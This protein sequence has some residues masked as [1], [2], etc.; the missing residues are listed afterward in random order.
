MHS[1]YMKRALDLAKAG[2]GR[3]SPNPTVGCVIVKNNQIIGEGRTA[4]GGRPHAEAV[5]LERAGQQAK[6]ATAYVT[7]EPCSHHGQ[8]PP[9]ARCLIDAG[10]KHVVVACED[11]NPQVAGDGIRMLQ[12]AGVQVSTG[13]CA[14]QAKALSAGFFLRFSEKRPFVT[15][16]MA[17]SADGKIAASGGAPIQISSDQSIT[18]MHRNLRATHDSILVGMETV[19][20]DNPRLTVRHVPEEN[21]HILTHV[22]LGDPLR[23][24]DD[25]HLRDREGE[26]PLLIYKT[27]NLTEVLEDL[28]LNHGLTRLMVEGGAQVMQSFLN[29]GLW[30]QIYLYHGSA[31]IGDDGVKAPDFT[32]VKNYLSETQKIGDDRL[33]IYTRQA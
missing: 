24:P 18:H 11:T 20:N 22:V 15:L 9:C 16:K 27:H 26:A 2:L 7:L 25:S 13:I 10:I 32:S 19:I 5:A 28:A 33:D 21:V 4:D 1:E 3:T 6:G 23:F 14:Q 29:A 12:D 8:T 17:L 30:D 31:I